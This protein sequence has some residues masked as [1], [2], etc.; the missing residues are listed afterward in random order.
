MRGR[1]TQCVHYVALLAFWLCN[2][3]IYSTDGWLRGWMQSKQI[4][5]QRE[6]WKRM[7]LLVLLTRR[8][9]SGAR[10]NTAAEMPL[11]CCSLR[12]F[13]SLCVC[14]FSIAWL[15]QELEDEHTGDYRSPSEEVASSAQQKWMP[16]MG[17]H[18]EANT[19]THTQCH[20]QKGCMD[21]AKIAADWRMVV[22][23][24]VAAMVSVA[25]AAPQRCFP[26]K[27]SQ[28]ATHCNNVSSNNK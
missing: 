11:C 28:P 8:W 17:I 10:R 25:A 23:A 19:Q 27:V 4:K 1:T 5:C 18:S 15:N 14:V 20:L 26:S 24:T 6:Y 7:L 9:L 16:Q 21:A 3:W 22:R 12:V 13:V 2:L